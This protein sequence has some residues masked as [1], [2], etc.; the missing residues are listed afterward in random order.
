M[1]SVA[2]I[3]VILALLTEIISGAT[4]T[5]PTAPLI[6]GISSANLSC[7]A[8]AG[9]ITSRQW[10]KDGQPLSPSNRTT[11]SEDNSFVSIDP[12]EGSDN[13]EYQ[14]TL[15]NPVSDDTA[16]YN[17]IVNYGPQDVVIQGEREVEVGQRVELKCSALSIPPATFTWTVNG[18]ETDVKTAE[19]TIEKATHGNSGD[20]ICVA[21]N[22]VTESTQASPVH[23]LAV[24]ERIS[25]ATI[26]GPTAALTAGNSSA[27]LSCQATAGTISSRQWLKDGQ[28]LSPSNRITISGDKSSVSINPV[29]GSDNGEYQCTLINPVSTETV[30]YALTVIYGPLDAVILGEDTAAVG[31]TVVLYCSAPSVPP[32]A[33]AWEVNG[34]QTGVRTAVYVIEMSNDTDSGT[35]ACLATNDV[36]G[37]S[38]SARHELT[39]KGEMQKRIL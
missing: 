1:E 14:C 33:F 2:L 38:A 23:V 13:G 22:A 34:T 4:I 17:L 11:I 7:Q 21:S 36:T 20:Y 3:A 10:L 26:T 16:S 37:L 6:A 28:P 5:G 35:Y 19:Y 15:I 9:T 39:V 25:G 27:N 8:T 29:E 12:V 31:S 18:T 32:P 30:S 24:Y